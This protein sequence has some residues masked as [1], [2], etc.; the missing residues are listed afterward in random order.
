M[1]TPYRTKFSTRALRSFSFS[2]NQPLVQR[3][4]PSLDGTIIRRRELQLRKTPAN[5]S[6]EGSNRRPLTSQVEFAK[7]DLK[8]F[9]A[10][11]LKHADARVAASFP[12][13]QG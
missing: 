8:Q 6:R 13:K 4:H 11:R 1:S 7:T 10:F 2:D 3:L 5:F 9:F 12:W